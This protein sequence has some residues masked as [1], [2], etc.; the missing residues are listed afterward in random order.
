MSSR[1]D[2]ICPASFPFGKVVVTGKDRCLHVAPVGEAKEGFV[3]LNL[4]QAELNAIKKTRR[5]RDDSKNKRRVLL[6][7][8]SLNSIV[9]AF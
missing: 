1:D 3:N 4:P 8:L 6:L 2:V 7:L 9:V 5:K